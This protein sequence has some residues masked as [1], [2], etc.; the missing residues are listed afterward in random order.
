[1]MQ[2]RLIGGECEVE[3]SAVLSGL[4]HAIAHTHAFATCMA[5]SADSDVFLFAA[6]HANGRAACV[7]SERFFQEQPDVFTPYGFGGFV[8]TGDLSGLHDAWV[9]FAES[10]GYVASYLMQ[11]PVLVPAEVSVSWAESILSDRHLY[12]I[13]LLLSVDERF[14]HVSSRKRAELKQWLKSAEPVTDQ[15]V[16][17]EAFARLYPAFAKRRKMAEHYQFSRSLLLELANLPEV[18]LVGVRGKDGKVSCVALMGSHAPC[19][20]Y[21]FMASSIEGERDGAG[22]IWLGLEGLAA[23]GVSMCNLGGG[24]H[25]GDGVAEMKRRLGGVARK[26]P[27]IQEIIDPDRYKALCEIAGCPHED[28]QFFPA[29]HMRADI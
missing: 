11:H 20:D 24:I 25:E 7:I 10:R 3:W 2:V 28:D 4:P 5:R 22:V 17:K 8:G 18:L 21:L 13:D 9:R 27:V 6:E 14:Q 16:L 19:G 29:Y 12:V 26:I 15:S 23:Q 1:M